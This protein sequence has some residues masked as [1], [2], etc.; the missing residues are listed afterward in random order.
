[1]IYDGDCEFCRRWVLRWEKVT[2]DCV[3]YRQYQE[4]LGKFPQLSEEDCMEAVQL[5]DVDGKVY[6]AAEAVLKSLAYNNRWEWLY[7]CY[8][9]NGF[10]ARMAE[11][12]Y[13][14]VASNR[15]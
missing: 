10:F 6:S 11:R 13:K 7:V 9:K 5:V 12:F 4:V 8:K 2:G 14:W 3:K 15:S 1:M